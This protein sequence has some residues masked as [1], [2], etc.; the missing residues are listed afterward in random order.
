MKILIKNCGL[1]I[2]ESRLQKCMV[3]HGF[4]DTVEVLDNS[5]SGVSQIPCELIVNLIDS[6]FTLQRLRKVNE[7]LPDVPQLDFY[8]PFKTIP[9]HENIHKSV[10]PTFIEFLL[11]NEILKWRYSNSDSTAEGV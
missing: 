3:E 2:S 5:Y 8:V 6:N 11:G 1:K 4:D 7:H 10:D 9:V